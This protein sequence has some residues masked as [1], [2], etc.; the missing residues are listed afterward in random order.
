[1]TNRSIDKAVILAAG[2]GNRIS[3][4][5]A[6]TPKPLLP[7]DGKSTTF[8]DWH[9]RALA[10]AGVKEIYIV[11]NKVTYEAKLAAREEVSHT[12]RVAWILNPTEDLSTSGSGHSAW[13]A[14][15][16]DRNILDGRSRVVLMDAD[17][18]YEPR[19]YD[20]L[21]ES[22]SPRS[23]SLVCGDFR[24]TDEEVLVFSD[25][26]PPCLPRLHGKG[27][28]GTPLTQGLLCRGEATGIL[29]FEPGDHALVRQVTDW[30]IRFSTAKTRSEHEDITQRMMTLG[31]IDLVPFG[32]DLLFMECDTPE[33]YALLTTEL[34]PKI[35]ARL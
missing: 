20:L 23:K 34:Y 11:G 19:I 22:A 26:A 24:Q 3:K 17:I 12:T 1:M 13:Y 14:W 5:A 4:A 25:E 18:V 7:I 27:L 9:L 28:L 30:V 33:E 21:K 15:H 35:A 32:R 29:L 31:R 2:L 16:D 6:G 8:L 10:K